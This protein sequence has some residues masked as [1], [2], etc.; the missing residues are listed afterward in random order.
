[1][2]KLMLRVL[3]GVSLAIYCSAAKAEQEPDT[4]LT[5]LPTSDTSELGLAE[6][7]QYAL[8][9]VLQSTGVLK[10]QLSGYSL[11][12]FTTNDVTKA[13][14]VLQ[15]DLMSFTYMEKSRLS[16]F[17]FAKAR[18][19]QFIVAYRMLDDAPGGQLSSEFIETRFR[20]AVNEVLTNYNNG[21]F[22]ALPGSENQTVAMDEGEARQKA[23][24]ARILFRELA[25]LENK[26]YYM[27]ANIG[28]ARFSQ[29]TTGQSIANSTVNFGGYGGAKLG[30]RMAFEAG[31]DVFSYLL[32]HGDIRY[33]MPLL[34]KY[35]DVSITGGFGHVMA[36]VTENR[37]Q[38][39]NVSMV[40]STVFGPGIAFDVPLLG[41]TVRGDVR[42]Y[43]GSSSILVGSYGVII[44]L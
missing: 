23:E 31:A 42:Y 29:Q 27:G 18:P 8:G 11:P 1:M 30:D 20:E 14:D 21:A 5:V 43:F 40:G 38:T 15:S 32:L 35:V 17:L 3:L 34:E 25:S 13:F 44:A 41:A 28:M 9:Q 6:P 36:A 10:V 37:N 12:G 4:S 24:E 33:H 16:V 26:K 22:Q 2:K 7:L 39:S 19:S